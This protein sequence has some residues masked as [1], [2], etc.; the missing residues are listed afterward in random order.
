M[1][2]R[3]S[4]CGLPGWPPCRL[5][6]RAKACMMAAPLGNAPGASLRPGCA[7]DCER[8]DGEAGRL[9]CCAWPLRCGDG[10][11]S[12]GAC[13]CCCR[14]WAAPPRTGAA[15][16]GARAVG[17]TDGLGAGAGA[18]DAPSAA[19]AAAAAAAA[20]AAVLSFRLRWENQICMP[21]ECTASGAG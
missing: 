4:S 8:P 5:V 13:C 2:F 20:A 15:A 19:G 18:G 1:L 9:C 14:S 21:V 17:L 16:C 11:R 7:G 6:L 10:A 3:L 12:G